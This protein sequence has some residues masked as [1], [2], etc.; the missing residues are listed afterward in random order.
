MSK[1][2]LKNPIN[3]GS[4]A[5]LEKEEKS[6]VFYNASLGR[7]VLSYLADI[8][9]SFI[10]CVFV[11]EIIYFPIT[12]S[13]IGYEQSVD[14][15]YKLGN[16]RY[17]L[18]YENELLYYKDNKETRNFDADFEYTGDLFTKFYVLKDN[19]GVTGL[20]GDPIMHY[21]E[22]I[23]PEGSK[24]TKLEVSLMYYGDTGQHEYFD[25]ITPE[26]SPYLTLKDNYKQ[27]WAPYFDPSDTVSDEIVAEIKQFK[28]SCF[29]SYSLANITD[30]AKN[31][32]KYVSYSTQ[33]DNIQKE[34]NFYYQITTAG[35]FLTVFI[36]LF[37][38]TPLVDKKGRT[39][40]K[41]IL[42]LERVNSKNFQY[43]PKKSRIA[44][45]LLTL[46]EQIPVILFI[47]LISVGITEIFTLTY[48]LII[49]IIGVAYVLVDLFICIAN[50][51]NFS[52]KEFLTT[53]V[54][55]D[56]DLMDKYYREVVYG[57]ERTT[58]E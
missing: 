54:V 17:D 10:L 34:F 35:A 29:R 37:V 19:P 44:V 23:A 56:K 13:C 58:I 30:F 41:M 50:K 46:L 32:E 18:L 47:P 16:E 38:V 55:V 15:M 57:E 22:K 1:D 51:L 24:K 11:L 26:S 45:I 31:N 2:L 8:F 3:E 39:I 4:A 27:R 42:K 36:A 6:F 7:R 40:G 52:I 5:I 9:I 25:P 14:T 20:V 48:L 53:S 33:I 12:K 28:L 21:Y 43:L 49:C